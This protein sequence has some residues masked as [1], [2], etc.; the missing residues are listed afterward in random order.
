[1]N[2]Q[3][4]TVD[5][6]KLDMD[7]RKIFFNMFKGFKL[8]TDFFYTD[9]KDGGIGFREL[10]ERKK[11]LALTTFVVYFVQIQRI[12]ETFQMIFLE[13]I[14]KD[15]ALTFLKRMKIF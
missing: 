4:K 5:L 12:S 9:W 13:E 14:F 6:Q 11:V 1:M 7:I 15:A 8:P 3:V 2:G 10:D